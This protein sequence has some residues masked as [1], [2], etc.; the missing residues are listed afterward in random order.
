MF[1]QYSEPPNPTKQT[2]NMAPREDNGPF[3]FEDSLSATYSGS[4]STLEDSPPMSPGERP[5][6]IPNYGTFGPLGENVEI[7]RHAG[8]SE[9]LEGRE[10]FM[11]TA[12]TGC[13]ILVL[14]LGISF[15]WGLAIWLI[16]KYWDE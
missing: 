9:E 6:R 5:S 15:Y 13:G 1:S 4:S 3:P 10:G 11:R 14:G 12:A 8:S 16:V 2:A 7:G